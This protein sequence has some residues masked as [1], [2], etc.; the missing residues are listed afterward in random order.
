MRSPI[1]YAMFTKHELLSHH[2]L[3]QTLCPSF[4]TEAGLG[5]FPVP[6]FTAVTKLLVWRPWNHGTALAVSAI[7][8]QVRNSLSYFLILNRC[9]FSTCSFMIS[10]QYLQWFPIG[11]NL[12]WERWSVASVCAPECRRPGFGPHV[13][14]SA[15]SFLWG[16]FLTPFL[17]FSH[18]V[19]QLSY[20]YVCMC[21]LG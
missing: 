4:L 21:M 8:I 18:M 1:G 20:L 7:Q 2:I 10:F 17:R 5:Q 19:L 15:D 11:A 9:S 13:S 6:Y 12:R 3:H 16:C 14:P